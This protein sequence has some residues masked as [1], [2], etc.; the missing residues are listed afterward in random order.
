MRSGPLVSS[1]VD[2]GLGEE[3]SPAGPVPDPDVPEERELSGAGLPDNWSGAGYSEFPMELPPPGV[4][5]ENEWPWGEITDAPLDLPPGAPPEF[6]KPGDGRGGGTAGSPD[7]DLSQTRWWSFMGGLA[8]LPLDDPLGDDLSGGAD[9]FGGMPDAFEDLEVVGPIGL[10]RLTGG[11]TVFDVG[12]Q[13]NE[14]LWSLKPLEREGFHMGISTKAGY[15]SNLDLDEANEVADLTLT[16]APRFSYRSAP[17]GVPVPGLVTLR[18]TPF[19]RRYLEESDRSRVDHMAS[20]DVGFTGTRGQIQTS[21][22]YG[23][24]SHADRTVGGRQETESFQA[25]ASASYRL[26]PRTFLEANLLGKI[27]RDQRQDPSMMGP[28]ISSESRN[29][30]IQ[31]AG[32]WQAT[33]KTRLGPSVRY[34]GSSTSNRG[35]RDSWAFLMVADHVP[36]SNLSLHGTLGVEWF[37]S[38]SIFYPEGHGV[39][40]R[41]AVNYRP[42]DRIVLAVD[43]RHE[44]IPEGVD[45]VTR[46]GGGRRTLTGGARCQYTPNPQW[47]M[48]LRANANSFPLAS[49]SNYDVNELNYRAMVTRHLPKGSLSVEGTMGFSDYTATG[50]VTTPISD[51]RYRSVSLLYERPVWF[52][53]RGRFH[54]TIRWSDNSGNDEWEQWQAG[55]GLNFEF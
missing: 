30:Q 36:R 43:L 20:A 1:E 31:L 46:T 44:A 33:A 32:F 50:P 49:A 47:T 5:S 18:Y 51:G 52:S 48:V 28:G 4:L 26:A 23:R 19:I 15:D 29:G 7:V 2:R 42:S 39:T 6:R 40:G 22:D 25:L 38:D 9:L 13:Q 27:S 24:F 17:D 10:T 37:N 8:D 54:S 41:F 3:G 34:S 14:L 12:L 55:V 45:S 53:E 11:P 21:A 16:F 35:D